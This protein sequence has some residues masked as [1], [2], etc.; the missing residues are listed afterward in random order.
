MKTGE[1]IRFLREQLDV[2]QTTFGNAIGQNR[3]VVARWEAGTQEPKPLQLMRLAEILE[4]SPQWMMKGIGTPPV[5]TPAMQDALRKAESLVSMGYGVMTYTDKGPSKAGNR[6]RSTT[7]SEQTA[8]PA[9]FENFLH[10][11]GQRVANLMQA[12]SDWPTIP[13]IPPEVMSAFSRQRALP[14]MR[15][16]VPFAEA[17]GVS[18]EWLLT[19]QTPEGATREKG[20]TASE[21]SQVTPAQKD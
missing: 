3:L 15:M 10:A 2:S 14:S 21:D 1:R 20:P 4:I 12:R 5:A 13:G 8:A 11:F 19:G 7:A 16:I 6:A 17:F 9:C 18:E